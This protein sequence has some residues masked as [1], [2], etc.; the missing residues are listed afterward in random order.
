M[1]LRTVFESQPERRYIMFGG[2][3]GLGRTTLSATCAF[4]LASQGKRVLLFSVD[5]Q[6]SLS[7]IFQKDIFGKG[8]V[9]IIQNLWAQEADAD[10]RGHGHQEEIRKKILDM[11]GFDRVPEEIDNYIAAASA[12]PAMEESAIFDAV[13]DIVV[14]GDYDYHIYD[15]LTGVRPE[16]NV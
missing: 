11:S 4:W 14:Q 5:P 9:P 13:V 12:E 16:R 6:A 7:D 8:P 10:R 15:L 2:K 1:S 3:G